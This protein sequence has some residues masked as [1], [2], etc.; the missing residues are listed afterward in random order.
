PWPRR[1]KERASAIHLEAVVTVTRRH[2]H[3]VPG[4][5]SCSAT[6][7]LERYPLIRS[8]TSSAVASS[9]VG[10]SRPSAF[11]VFTLITNLKRSFKQRSATAHS[12]NSS[13]STGDAYLS[14][15]SVL[16]RRWGSSR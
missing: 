1:G 11:A 13:V 8:I 2:S 14:H 10:P 6:S 7:H 15:A 4:A 3:F 16:G 5:D 9:V 12:I